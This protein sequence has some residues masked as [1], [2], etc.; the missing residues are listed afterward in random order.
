[1]WL[2]SKKVLPKQLSLIPDFDTSDACCMLTVD[3]MGFKSVSIERPL[4]IVQT[5][6]TSTVCDA[7]TT[8]VRTSKKLSLC[9]PECIWP[10]M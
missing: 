7:V 3:S 5:K 4:Q 8:D 9:G 10:F 2:T 6:S 1:M